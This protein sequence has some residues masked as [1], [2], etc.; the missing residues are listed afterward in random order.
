MLKNIAKRL[1]RETLYRMPLRLRRFLFN[2]LRHARYSTPAEQKKINDLFGKAISASRSGHFDTAESCLREA[3]CLDPTHPQIAPHLERIRFLKKRSEDPASHEQN[4]RMMETIRAMN[5]ELESGNPIYIPSEFWRVHGRYHLE[6][7]ESYGIE[8]FKRTVSHYYQNWL[9][10][11]LHDPQVRRIFATWPS[12]FDCSPWFARIEVPSHVGFH[13]SFNFDECTYPL[14]DADRREIYRL[15]VSL[16]WEYVKRND[17]FNIMSQ[18]SESEI[19]NPIRIWREGR[20]ISS[21]IAHSVRERN[22]ILDNLNLN[23]SENYVIGELGA[24]HGRLA[25]V[26]GLTTNYR[27]FIFDIPPALYVAQWYIKAIFPEAKLFE[28]RHFDDF[29]EIHD[30]LNACRFA[31]FTANQIEKI[32]EN[33]CDIFINSTSLMEMRMDQISHFLNQ[34]DRL[35]LHAFFSRQFINWKNRFDKIHVN[36]NTFAM[37]S[38]WTCKLDQIDDVYPDFFNQIWIKRGG[39]FHGVSDMT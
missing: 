27:Y 33:C 16:L 35:T 8:N 18:L 24:G 21:D 6:L 37:N 26:F 12:H 5:F 28:F 38:P 14:A 36:K 15:A 3:T 11:Y 25:E 7:L 19:G 29:D 20:L 4:R 39:P 1:I 2:E 13:P 23:G 22:M 31:F 32:P 10:I 17:K 30:E 34:I 9:M